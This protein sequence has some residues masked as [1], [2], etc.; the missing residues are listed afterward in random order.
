MRHRAAAAAAADP[1][2]GDRPVQRS[3]VLA[4]RL[5]GV[6]VA[7][8]RVAVLGRRRRPVGAARRARPGPARRRVGAR[9]RAV[10][11]SDARQER[12]PDER[13][14][15]GVT[16]EAGVGGVPVASVVAHLTL[17]DADRTCARVARLGVKRLEARAAVG[18]RRTHDVALTAEVLFALETLEVTHV[19]ALALRLRTLV[20]EYYLYA[21]TETAVK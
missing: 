8:L 5:Q 1:E 6:V 4:R 9:R 13:P 15:A 19:P 16:R 17:V 12:L 2:P 11:A 18:A 20:R 7:R 10:D 21:H 14:G 3:A